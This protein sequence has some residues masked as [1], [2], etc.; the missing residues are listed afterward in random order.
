MTLFKD[1]AARVRADGDGA[2]ADAASRRPR[3][4]DRA[5]PSER[6]TCLI[7]PNDLAA[8]EAGRAA[9]RARHGPLERRLLARRGS[10]RR[11]GP[12]PGGRDPER[13]RAGGDPGRA[14]R[15]RRGRRGA[16]GRGPARRRRREGAARPRGRPGRP[17]VRHRLDRPARHAAEL[18][19]DDGLRH[20]A[21]GRLE[22]PVLRVPARGGPGAR[23]AD[24]HRRAH[25]RDPLPDGAS[26][27]SATPR[28]RC[29]RCSR[30]SSARPT[31]PGR[32]RSSDQVAGL[33][34]GDGAARA[35]GRRPDQPAA[36]L[37]GALAAAAGRLHPHRRLGLGR[38]LVRA[39]P[40]AAR[41]G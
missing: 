37:L 11:G 33:V 17:A 36:R 31:G 29:A 15:A 34:E 39:R 23:R 14:G 13:G 4:A 5:S 8:L 26:T 40:Q 18:R 21:D 6:V 7:V 24:R 3:G 25:A 22:L 10:S 20:A 27:S 35:R 19:A 38:Q 41:A 1:V 32:R 9:A 12:A 30:C 28:R 2:G 16:R